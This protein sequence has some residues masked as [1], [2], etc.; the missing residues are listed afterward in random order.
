MAELQNGLKGYG[1]F[2]GEVTGVFDH[3]TDDAV[4][5]FQQQ[6]GLPV[7]GKVGPETWNALAATFLYP[8]SSRTKAPEGELSIV[9]DLNKRQLQLY[10]DG[11]LHKTYPVA[12][13][14]PRTP[15]PVGEWRIV[16]KSRNWGGGFGTRWLGL[17]VPWGI[18]GIHGTNK[19]WSISRAE[20]AGCFRMYNHQV[21]ELYRWVKSGTPVRV[22]GRSDPEFPKRA[23]RRG[24][25]GQD[26]VYLQL[27]LRE[28]GYD[29]GVADA[30]FGADTENAVK[31]L[32]TY[33]G[34]PADGIAGA[35]TYYLLEVK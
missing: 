34:L 12:I 23:L 11:H 19:P 2:T 17:N 28:M 13:G 31:A 20:S 9:I 5:R 22:V 21:E 4:K 32:Q 16:H 3:A 24:N 1:F 30:R 29:A 18:Y 8:V 14:K 10:S 26:V 27:A 7:D 35:D 25:S 33:Y 15:S 6:A